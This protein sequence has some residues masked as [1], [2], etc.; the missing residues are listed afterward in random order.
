M[1][2]KHKLLFIKEILWF[3]I[4]IYTIHQKNNNTYNIAIRNS[5][6]LLHTFNRTPKCKHSYRLWNSQQNWNKKTNPWLAFKPVVDTSPPKSSRP[7]YVNVWEST[8]KLSWRNTSSKTNIQCL[9]SGLSNDIFFFKY[10]KKLLIK[11]TFC[12]N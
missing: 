12:L 5:F 11:T 6:G 3:S 2:H 10:L 1:Q 4:Y 7:I 9:C 8:L